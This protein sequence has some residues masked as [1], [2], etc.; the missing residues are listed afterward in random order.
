M[1][2]YC[3][4]HHESY[5]E[6]IVLPIFLSANTLHLFFN[7]INQK[8][9]I[10]IMKQTVVKIIYTTIWSLCLLVVTFKDFWNKDFS[11]LSSIDEYNE[12]IGYPLLTSMIL[13]I[14]DVIFN[15]V[16]ENKYANKKT[17]TCMLF[18]LFGLL[19]TMNYKNELYIKCCFYLVWVSLTM[20]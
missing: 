20:M 16:M 5:N 1:S 3:I 18:F 7:K 4:F 8:L 11:S 15:L 2:G 14:I 13:F 17:L 9:Y 6:I 10:C 12:Q 19:G